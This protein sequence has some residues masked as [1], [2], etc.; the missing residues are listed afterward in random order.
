MYQLLLLIGLGGSGEIPGVDTDVGDHGYA[1]VNTSSGLRETV[2]CW[3]GGCQGAHA[4]F[5]DRMRGR[6]W[7]DHGCHGWAGGCFGHGAHPTGYFDA[8]A[9]DGISHGGK[10]VVIDTTETPSPMMVPD[11]GRMPALELPTDGRKAVPRGEPLPAPRP[12]EKEASLPAPAVIVVHLPPEAT[13][14]V[15]G[16]PTRLASGRREFA[17]PPLPPGRDFTYT[18][19]AR[20]TRAG[21]T[22]LA[23]RHVTVRAGQRTRLD[24]EF[25]S[26]S[27]AQK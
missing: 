7:G 11:A 26:V 25:P 27:V 4:G 3:A 1:T 19:E 20:I 9:G 18:F 24:L 8:S 6:W 5:F 12:K 10:P 15:D 21:E 2:G 23:S 13:L 17:S 22:V 16:A 14:S